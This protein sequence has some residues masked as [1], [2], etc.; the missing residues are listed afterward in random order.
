ML[1]AKQQSTVSVRDGVGVTELPKV[2]TG[3]QLSVTV[4]TCHSPGCL[5]FLMRLAPCEV[6]LCPPVCQF[7]GRVRLVQ[8][9]TDLDRQ[10]SAEKPSLFSTWV[11]Y[12]HCISSPS[13]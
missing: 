10:T 11:S 6:L 2:I 3:I 5:P 1:K 13:V 9:C 7:L 8:V 12:W 4:G